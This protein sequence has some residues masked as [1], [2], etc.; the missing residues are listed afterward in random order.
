MHFIKLVQRTSHL[1]QNIPQ[2]NKQ[3]KKVNSEYP[4]HVRWLG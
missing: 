4:E 1:S 2:A 3:K